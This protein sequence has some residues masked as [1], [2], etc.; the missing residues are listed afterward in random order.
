MG[1]KDKPAHSRIEGLFAYKVYI[2]S[3]LPSAR[4]ELLPNKAKFIPSFA[5]SYRRRV[6]F[7]DYFPAIT[8]QRWNIRGARAIKIPYLNF[9]EFRTNKIPLLSPIIS[10]KLRTK[11][12]IHLDM[13]Y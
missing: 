10:K 11:I 1:T 5:Y 8:L 7:S 9:A 12:S 6:P 4:V 13:R 2:L 3:F